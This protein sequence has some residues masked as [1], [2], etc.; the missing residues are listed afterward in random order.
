MQTTAYPW[1]LLGDMNFI[2]RNREKSG[3][4]PHSQNMLNNANDFVNALRVHDISF[5]GNLFTWTNRRHDAEL[6]QERL[7]R[8]LGDET[9]FNFFPDCH[10]YHLATISSDHGPIVLT[11][12]KQLNS[13]K[14]PNKFNKCCLRDSSC[15]DINVEDDYWKQRAKDDLF[16]FDNRY[17][18]YC[19]S[20]DNFRMKKTNIEFIKDNTGVWLTGGHGIAVNLKNHF[21]SISRTSNPTHNARL[22]YCVNAC[23]TNADNLCLM[24]LPSKDKIKDV[25]FSMKPWTSPGPD[26]FPPGFYQNMWDII[27]EDTV[28]MVHCF[29]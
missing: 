23:V 25:V 14:K 10:V 15:N 29:F 22:F 27:G 20:R 17:T 24:R 26:G 6:I 28:K 4:N 3:G 8:F 2:L 5:F 7:D 19:H 13:A 11:S 12:S 18:S 16:K 9:W 1:I 21:S